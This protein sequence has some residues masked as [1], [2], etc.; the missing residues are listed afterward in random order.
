[1]RALSG[2]PRVAHLAEARHVRHHGGLVQIAFGYATASKPGGENHDTFGAFYLED[3][4]LIIVCDGQGGQSTALQAAT[5]AIEVIHQSIGSSSGDPD[6]TLV[7]SLVA[8]NRAIYEESRKN[9]RLMGMSTSVVAALIHEQRAYI[10]H[11]GNCRAYR[12]GTGEHGPSGVTPLTRDHTMVNMFV[13]NE[14]LS[15]EDAASHPEAH[16]LSRSLGTERQV[17]I[18]LQEVTLA[19][20]DVI[21]LC[22]DGVHRMIDEP[23]LDGL[24]WTKIE[25]AAAYP[26]R[27]AH[28]KGGTDAAT[29]VVA[30][31]GGPT[32]QGMPA[33]PLPTHESS[34]DQPTPLSLDSVRAPTLFDEPQP[35]AMYPIDPEDEPTEASLDATDASPDPRSDDLRSPPKSTASPLP[36]RA[37]IQAQPKIPVK[38]TRRPRRLAPIIGISVAV[39]CFVILGGA[40]V[41]RQVRDHQQSE[42]L[43][44]LADPGSDA[45]PAQGEPPRDTDAAASDDP[46]NG[47]SD[48]PAD[49]P[50][51]P[52]VPDPGALL[53]GEVDIAREPGSFA[54]LRFPPLRRNSRSAQIY[55]EAPPSPAPRINIQKEIARA[56][57]CSAVEDIIEQSLRQSP[58]FAPLYLDLWNCY[59]DLH[60]PNLGGVLPAAM[61]F[62]DKRPHLEGTL[63]QPNPSKP[64]PL[65]YLPATDGIERRMDLYSQSARARDGFHDVVNDA[66]DERILASRFHYDLLAEAAYALAFSTLPNPTAEQIQDW[67]R[68]VYVARKHR[69]SPVGSLVQQLEPTAARR[70]DAVLASATFGFEEAYKDGLSQWV[71][72]NPG[73]ERQTFDWHALAQRH[74]LPIPVAHALLVGADHLPPPTGVSSEPEDEDEPAPTVRRDPCQINPADPRCIPGSGG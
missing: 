59:Q 7:E 70:V 5:L 2:P 23:S 28:S 13:D 64:L 31:Y 20:G 32:G 48:P 16:V 72:E 56:N 41:Y 43:N 8:A 6:L 4:S 65:W 24:D 22:S 40:F 42:A 33:T 52:N 71:N 49:D 27:R 66:V 47:D 9:H 68:R 57:G 11:V 62:S 36:P 45:L 29:V 19:E 34:G 67:A 35:P 51:E 25:R 55:T 14:L 30:R 3:W 10:A 18:D 63:R 21:L 38:P 46:P 37:A 73:V 26:I 17:D 50:V 58:S 74:R 12:I 44:A 60:D 53:V 61:H 69:D 39:L 15:P 54:S 1:M